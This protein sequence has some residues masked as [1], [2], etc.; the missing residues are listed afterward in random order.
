MKK[1]VLAFKRGLFDSF[2]IALGYFPVAV[3]FGVAAMAAGVP[4]WLAVLISVCVY[5]GASQFI[6]IMLLAQSTSVPSMILIVIAVNM[7][8]LFYGPALLSQLPQNTRSVPLAL[9]AFGLTDEVFAAAR[10][11][12]VHVDLD[13]QEYWYMGLQLGAYLSWVLGTAVGAY[14]ANDW[15]A[16]QPILQQ[17]LAFV[18]PALFF[19]LLLDMLHSIDIRIVIGATVA[20]LVALFFLPAHLS[21]IVGMVVG[22][23]CALTPTEKNTALL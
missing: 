12:L 9:M 15:L 18:L 5:A 16:S 21:L 19:A 2:S 11:R 10:A 22:S 13:G 6:L 14:I 23:L 20:T 8:H 3:S 4:A 17:S 1:M 7:R